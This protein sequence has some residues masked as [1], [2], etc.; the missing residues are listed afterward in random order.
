MCL[1]VKTHKGE[2]DFIAERGKEKFY[3]QAAYL[4]SDGKGD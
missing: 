3:I 4:L 2:V 1:L